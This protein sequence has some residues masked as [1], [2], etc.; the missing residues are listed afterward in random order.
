[1]AEQIEQVKKT[2][3]STFRNI[4]QQEHSAYK[5]PCDSIGT[6]SISDS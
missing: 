1:M 6:G 5:L 2:L 4:L 3:P